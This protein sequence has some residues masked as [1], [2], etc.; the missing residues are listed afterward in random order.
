MP[1]CSYLYSDPFNSLKLFEFL[2]YLDLARNSLS[3]LRKQNVLKNHQEAREA[4]W[5]SN[6][7]TNIFD[8]SS[9]NKSDR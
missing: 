2:I 3:V 7:F 4:S 8:E 5:T 6:L 9:V 1:T